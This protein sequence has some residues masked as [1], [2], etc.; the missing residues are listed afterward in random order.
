MSNYREPTREDVDSIIEVSE[1]PENDSRCRWRERRLVSIQRCPTKNLFR[2]GYTWRTPR[3]S[4]AN[5]E[6]ILWEYARIK[7]EEPS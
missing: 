3:E 2:C 1:Y 6:T 4:L 5:N 7:V